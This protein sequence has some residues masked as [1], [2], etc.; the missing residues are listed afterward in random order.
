[1]N[2]VYYDK[3][4]NSYKKDVEIYKPKKNI[5]ITNEITSTTF[6]LC[7]EK[8]YEL[9]QGTQ[10]HG[11]DKKNSLLCTPLVEMN[12]SLLEQILLINFQLNQK[13]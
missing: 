9:I 2:Q 1:M 4:I 10:K 3:L 7:L 12:A 5:N 8:Q 6:T 13:N 11:L